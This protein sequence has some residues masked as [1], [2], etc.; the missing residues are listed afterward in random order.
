MPL[1]IVLDSLGLHATLTTL[2]EGKD[3]RLHPTVARI[4]DSYES[5]EIDEIICIPGS[6]NIADALTKRNIAIQRTLG[7]ILVD[8]KFEDTIFSGAK[9]F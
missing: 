8:G 4:R 5:K 6:Q 3:Y 2:H 7:K 9:S 1:V